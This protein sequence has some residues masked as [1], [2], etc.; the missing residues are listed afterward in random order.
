[1][2]ILNNISLLLH[3]KNTTQKALTDY[4]GLS[5]N[6]FTDWKSGKCK[7][8]NNYLPQIAEFFNISIDVL[9][10]NK[11][12]QEGIT[13]GVWEG[14]TDFTYAAYEELTHDLSTEQIEQLKTYA[15]FLRQQK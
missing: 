5:K 13:I 4:L 1:M 12:R 15:D 9:V 3:E 10:G 14:K 7:S 8:Y 11:P 6:I 2:H